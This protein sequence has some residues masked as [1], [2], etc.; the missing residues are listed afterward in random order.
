MNKTVVALAPGYVAVINL[1]KG[2]PGKQEPR[3]VNIL[4]TLQGV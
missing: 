2:E 4:D 1:Q 3:P